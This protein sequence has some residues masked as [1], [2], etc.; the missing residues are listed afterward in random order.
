[1]YTVFS[2]LTPVAFWA[3]RRWGWTT[4]LAASL[5][6]WLLAQTHLRDALVAATHTL[7]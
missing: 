6:L 3:A 1:M 4:V 5:F 2:W 7:S